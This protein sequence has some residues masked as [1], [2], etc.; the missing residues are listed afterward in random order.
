VTRDAWTF[1]TR[2]GETFLSCGRMRMRLRLDVL[3]FES[4]RRLYSVVKVSLRNGRV[5]LSVTSDFV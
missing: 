4:V 1:E 3:L 5:R 2:L